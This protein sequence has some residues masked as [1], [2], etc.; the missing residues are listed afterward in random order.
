MAEVTREISRRH[1]GLVLR[2]FRAGRPHAT[3]TAEELAETSAKDRRGCSWRY[4]PNGAVE[5]SMSGA[6]IRSI[7]SSPAMGAA[8]MSPY[9]RTKSLEDVLA[10]AEEAVEERKGWSGSDAPSFTADDL[11]GATFGL[12]EGIPW[13]ILFFRGR[14]ALAI[15]S[16]DLNLREAEELLEWARRR[17]ATALNG[18]SMGDTGNVPR[19]EMWQAESVVQAVKDGFTFLLPF[20]EKDSIA[21]PNAYWIGDVQ[22]VAFALTVGPEHTPEIGLRPDGWIWVHTFFTPEM[23]SSPG[24]KRAWVTDRPNENGVVE[25]LVFID[26]ETIDWDLLNRGTQER[27]QY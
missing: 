14:L 10:A 19:P 9:T 6:E 27:V 25:V 12:V 21:K 22:Y 11:V 2:E 23:V 24:A 18:M 26:P 16:R 17:T 3:W 4:D 1:P 7:L 13:F 8:G 5:I 20:V 15:K